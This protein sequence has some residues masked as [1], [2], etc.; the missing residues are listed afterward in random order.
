MQSVIVRHAV[1]T[2][3]E[4]D[5]E[6]FIIEVE[7][8]PSLWNSKSSEYAD[9]NKK[10][11]NWEE[12]VDIFGADDN[13]L[14]EK[15][16]LGKYNIFLFCVLQTVEIIYAYLSCHSSL[17]SVIKCSANSSRYLIALFGLFLLSHG[18]RLSVSGQDKVSSKR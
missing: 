3:M 12:L 14:A 17:P 15:K 8:R 2:S 7:R 13:T 16:T 6:K 1:R 18:P 5:T 9:R 4:F 11:R 10:V